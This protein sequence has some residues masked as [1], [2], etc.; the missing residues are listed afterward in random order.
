MNSCQYSHYIHQYLSKRFYANRNVSQSRNNQS[1]LYITAS[2]DVS[3]HDARPSRSYEQSAS[4][5]SS[6]SEQWRELRNSG[7]ELAGISVAPK[8]SKKY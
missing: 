1:I 4:T 6:P 2:P 3:S 7:A 5:A 8:I